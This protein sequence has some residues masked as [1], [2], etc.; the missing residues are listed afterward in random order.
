MLDVSST[1]T[2][3][4]IVRGEVGKVVLQRKLISFYALHVTVCYATELMKT[5][6]SWLCA[7][8]ICNSR[9]PETLS[10]IVVLL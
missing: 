8:K 3:L 5:C 1:F 10:E 2:T 6:P 9:T 4:G 7:L